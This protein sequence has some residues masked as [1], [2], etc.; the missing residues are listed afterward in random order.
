MVVSQIPGREDCRMNVKSEKRERTP[1]V[2]AVVVAVACTAH[3]TTPEQPGRSFRER[4]RPGSRIN[5]RQVCDSD[6]EGKSMGTF[7]QDV[8]YGARMLWKS[9]GF[10]IIAVLTL[11]LGIG[12]NTS[13]F[14]VVNEVLLNPLPYP[15]PDQ[16][17]SAYTRTGNFQR[18]SVSYLNFLDWQKDNRSFAAMAAIRGDH[19]NLTGQGE[20]EHLRGYAVSADYFSILDARPVLGRVFNREEDRVG[21]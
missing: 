20:A 21:A 12:D 18:S 19:Y 11:A 3:S 5:F 17:V 16:L 13:L 7:W 10:T 9:L 2:S 6:Q 8:R 15:N 1:A 4:R 14:S